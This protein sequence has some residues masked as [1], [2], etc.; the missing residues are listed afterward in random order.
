MLELDI[1]EAK[2]NKNKNRPEN[3]VGSALTQS[4]TE[5]FLGLTS[6]LQMEAFGPLVLIS[7][8]LCS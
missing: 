2:K 5:R 7:Q 1:K 3:R 8:E 4:L 6:L